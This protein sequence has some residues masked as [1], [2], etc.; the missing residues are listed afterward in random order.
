MWILAFEDCK[1]ESVTGY[2]KFWV[3]FGSSPDKLGVSNK[4]KSAAT[5]PRTHPSDAAL[6]APTHDCG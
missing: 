4:Q 2:N 5:S 1:I 6:P 3:S